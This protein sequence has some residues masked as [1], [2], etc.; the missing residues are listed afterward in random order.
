[1]SRRATRLQPRVSAGLACA[2][3]PPAVFM[4]SLPLVPAGVSSAEAR[5]PGKSSHFSVNWVAGHADVEIL[6]ATTGKRSCG[7]WSRLCKHVLSAR[8]AR[9]YGKVGEGASAGKPAGH[10]GQGPTESRW[11]CAQGDTGH[12]R[13]PGLFS[14]PQ[15]PAGPAAGG[16]GL[17]C[18]TW[19][20]QHGT[21]QESL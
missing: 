19:C 2:P 11:V 13:L 16:G 17:T 1:M 8:W 6:D 12:K 4:H 15:L 7:G 9:L 18:D 3:G 10:E 21:P 5:R 14:S 20:G